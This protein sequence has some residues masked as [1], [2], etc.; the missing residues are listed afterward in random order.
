[1]A[2]SVSDIQTLKQIRSELQLK[3][4]TELYADKYPHAGGNDNYTLY[5]E[6]PDRIKVELVLIAKE[7]EF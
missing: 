7:D 5:F 1:M 4:Y 3:G 6:D 2:F